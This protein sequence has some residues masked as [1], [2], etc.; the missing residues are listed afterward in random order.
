MAVLLLLTFKDGC[1]EFLQRPPFLQ[2][3][4][5][6]WLPLFSVFVNIYL[7]MQLDWGT[8][9]RFA[10]WML[11]GTFGRRVLLLR[12]ANAFTRAFC[13]FP[14]PLS[15]PPRFHHLLFLWY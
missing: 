13:N 10:V 8:W 6:P 11:I 7:M 14:S 9:C 5:L 4:L 2:V 12:I 15:F 3:P 1:A